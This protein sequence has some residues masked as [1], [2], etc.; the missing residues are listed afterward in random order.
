[1][2][3]DLLLLLYTT[4][5]TEKD[6]AEFYSAYQELLKEKYGSSGEPT[7]VEILNRDVLIVEGGAR[8]NLDE[9]LNFMK[10]T[11]RTHYQ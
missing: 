10:K 4:W 3:T 9:L 6:A 8:D 1:K 7:K 2:S 11:K 5:D